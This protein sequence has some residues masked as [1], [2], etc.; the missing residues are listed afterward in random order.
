MELRQLSLNQLS[1]NWHF[2]LTFLLTERHLNFNEFTCIL[3]VS[4]KYI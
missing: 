1:R 2:C 3:Y 4:N